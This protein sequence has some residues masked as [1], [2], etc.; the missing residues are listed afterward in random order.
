M[1]RFI[2]TLWVLGM[3]TGVAWYVA[4][5]AWRARLTARTELRRMELRVAEQWAREQMRRWA[6][7]DRPADETCRE[8]D[9]TDR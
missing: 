5:P 1:I 2:V 8:T 3:A 4:L 6:D 7:S 9:P